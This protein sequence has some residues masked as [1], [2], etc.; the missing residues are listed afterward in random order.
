MTVCLGCRIGAGCFSDGERNPDN[1]C[2]YCDVA[3]APEGWT[4]DDG[5][6]CDDGLYCTGVDTCDEEVCVHSGDPCGVS[7]TCWEDGGGQCCSPVVDPVCNA[8]DQVVEVDSCGHELSVLA[9][10]TECVD[11]RCVCNPVAQT[12]CG[13]G[14]KCAWDGAGTTCVPD[15]SVL[16][17]GACTAPSAGVDDCVAGAHCADSLCREICTRAPDSCGAV[18]LCTPQAGLFTGDAN[19]GLCEPMCDPVFQNCPATEACYLQAVTGVS[20]CAGIPE[21]SVSIGQ[22]DTCYG[23]EPG[24]CYL[25][26][27]DEG[28]GANLPG[29]GGVSVCAFFCTPVDSWKGNADNAAGDPY[30]VHCN[31]TF[32][33]IRPDGPGAGHECRFFQSFYSN[34]EDVLASVGMCVDVAT[35]GSCADF[36][37]VA[38]QAD[39]A[40]GA[41]QAPDYCDVHPDRCMDDCLSRATMDAAR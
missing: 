15:G 36:D 19:V 9:N 35:W 11:A 33:G 17:G 29:D 24:V 32:G 7:D 31:S 27:C 38:R 30:S 23:P 40:T 4:A 26:G 18:E 8:S 21:E 16:L 34:V 25:N 37:W 28:Y 5:A 14:E 1:P 22:G 12:G 3:G 41:D 20:S 13:G 6:P 2:Q 10:C 39:M